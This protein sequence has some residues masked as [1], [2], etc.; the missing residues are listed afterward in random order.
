MK[1]ARL[2]YS[3]HPQPSSLSKIDKTL[4]RIDVRG[5][6]VLD[7]YCGT[8]T[9]LAS[10]LSHGARSATGTDLEN[11]TWCLRRELWRYLDNSQLVGD[12]KLSLY[13]GVDATVAARTLDYDVLVTDPPNPITIV[14][15]SPISVPRDT[16]HTGHQL[17]QFWKERLDPN[18][19]M[20]A[21]DGA[22]EDVVD[23]ISHALDEGAR[24]IVNLFAVRGFDYLE[25]ISNRFSVVQIHDSW[26][27]VRP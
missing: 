20:G 18:N 10:A 5:Q 7:C 13:W 19:L 21:G 6:A 17:T 9:V 4:D 8:G 14:G 16:G 23:V 27:E 3:Y 11:Y 24:V 22:V 15:G 2:T 26:H 1:T 12:P 25:A